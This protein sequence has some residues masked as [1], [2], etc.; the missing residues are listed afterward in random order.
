RG[1]SAR[2]CVLRASPPLNSPANDLEA[3]ASPPKRG[4]CPAGAT[5]DPCHAAASRADSRR[6]HANASASHVDACTIV[7][8]AG[9]SFVNA[10]P[11]SLR[12]RA[13]SG[14]L[15]FGTR[16]QGGRNRE[17]DGGHTIPAFAS[18]GS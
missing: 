18:N 11:R 3:A 4:T 15:G 9:T 7:A 10:L 16:P 6:H 13:S 1:G 14:S 5:L 2:P 8:K 12:S 17:F